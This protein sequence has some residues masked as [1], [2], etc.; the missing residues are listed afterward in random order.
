MIASPLLLT[1][2]K[3]PQPSDVTQEIASS[4]APQYDKA[5]IESRLK[6]VESGLGVEA[7][8]TTPIHGLFEVSLN[9]GQLI[10]T[11]A[12]AR[13]VLNGKLFELS[14]KGLVDLGAEKLRANAYQALSAVNPKDMIIYPAK[15]TKTHI[16]IFTDVDC[17]YCQKLHSEVEALTEKGI[18]VRYLAFPR[19]GMESETA[20]RMSSIWCGEDRRASLDASL[21]QEPI[22]RASCD[23]PVRA[24]LEL[25]H[26]LGVSGTPAIFLADGT[27]K[28]GYSPAKELAVAAMDAEK[29][30]K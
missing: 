15:D 10:Y 2:C 25:G 20:G 27:L 6:T 14:D 18:E 9:N 24:Q 17:P 4:S 3:D 5:M 1:G 29:A 23:S 21:R 16:T 22:E 30:K 11:T 8:N 26:K 13:Y 19:Q 7:V 12:D 28:P